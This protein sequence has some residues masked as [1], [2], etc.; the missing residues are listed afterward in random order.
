MRAVNKFTLKVGK[1]ALPM[2][3]FKSADETTS[4]HAKEVAK[5]NGKIYSV[6]RKYVVELDDGT[7]QPIDSS[8]ILKSYEKD[9]GEIALFTKDEQAQ[10][11]KKGSSREWVANA[12]IDKTKFNELSFQKD[13]IIAMVEL[14]KKK[15]LLN[16]KNLKF[17]AMLKEGLQDR[18]IVTQVLYKN[19][20]YP[21]AISNFGDN[22]LIRFLH[23]SDEIREL[24]GQKLPPLN[25]Q[26]KE[27]AKAFIK[28]FYNPAFDVSS[29]QNKTEEQIMKLINSRGS[30]VEDSN[31]EQTIMEADNP[32]ALEGGMESDL[33]G[34]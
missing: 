9:D 3:C 21:V 25:D 33:A 5:V 11:L 1:L 16:K 14:D 32:F 18:V 10:L 8:Q 12:V 26:D 13:G 19:V 6:K 20:E 22:L 30:E 2:S 28:Q 17:F 29:F 31:T 15:E 23:Y 34:I 27:Q 24:D 7:E 4:V